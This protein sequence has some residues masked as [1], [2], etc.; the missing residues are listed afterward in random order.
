MDSLRKILLSII[1]LAFVQVGFGRTTPG[2]EENSLKDDA[3]VQQQTEQEQEF[4]GKLDQE[5]V[6]EV[7]ED[8]I[9]EEEEPQVEQDSLEDDSV[10]KYNFI[11]YFL[12]KFKY[13]HQDVTI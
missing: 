11:F 1:L 7:D 13:D 6:I 5:P 4:P 3:K 2:T 9:L 12:Y 8:P 10:N